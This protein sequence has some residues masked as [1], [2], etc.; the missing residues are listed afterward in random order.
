MG[1]YYLVF[2]ALT[3]IIKR[4]MLLKIYKLMA[5]VTMTVLAILLAGDAYAEN[6]EMS[7]A[8]H[9]INNTYETRIGI[10]LSFSGGLEQWCQP[11]RQG[12]EIAASEHN[13][14][15]QH[16]TDQP[17]R[18]G[19]KLVFEDDLSVSKTPT[20]TAARRLLELHKVDLLFTWTPSLAPILVPLAKKAQTPLVV[21]AFDPRMELGGDV[22]A[23]GISYE[24]LPRE[25][26]KLMYDRGARR[27]GLVM[28][29][30]NW[31]QG[32]EKPFKHEASKLGANVVMTETISVGDVDTRALI[33]K[34]KRA[35]V[36][37]VLAPLFGE[38]LHTFI[39][40]ARE[41]RYEG[42]IH[43]GDGLFKAD[44]DNL[45]SAAEGIYAAQIWLDNP[46]LMG[47]FK[48]KYGKETDSLS[49]G[50]VAYGYD[51]I[52]HIRAAVARARA[53][54]KS[55]VSKEQR[56]P[57]NLSA[58]RDLMAASLKGLSTQGYLGN[59]SLDVPPRGVIASMVVVKNGEY[60]LVD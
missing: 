39:K 41:L 59:I 31:S 26:A 10:L 46:E 8:K 40:T 13:D 17:D 51:L 2:G 3:N 47:K 53:T 36:E 5:I 11:I 6:R 27:L 21:G 20:L 55:S 37:G 35:E 25:I 15:D 33:L 9:F 58:D 28:E 29:N 42:L 49:L 1:G 12:M 48:A 56:S 16:N 14:L 22:F 44:I 57:V 4:N 24:A 43:V 23:W 60:A 54:L 45:G 18:Y 52:A 38:A 19:F 32:F 34:L 30:D 50:L 7:A